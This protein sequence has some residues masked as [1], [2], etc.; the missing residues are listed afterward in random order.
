M[1]TVSLHTLGCKL[2]H[3]ETSAMARQFVERG[4]DVVE[5]GAGSDV[6]V[7]NTC[8]VTDRADRECRQLIR[9]SLRAS[10]NS[11]VL[12]TGCYAQLQPEEVASIEGVGAVLG[13]REKFH[14]FEYLNPDNRDVAQVHVS[15]ISQG[16]DFG[17]AYSSGESGRTRGF[18]KVQDGCDYNCSFCTIPLARGISRSQPL[19]ACVNQA[20]LLASQGYREIVLTGVNVGDYGRKDSGGL[21]EL[22]RELEAVPGIERIRISS[23]EP[24]LLTDAVIDRVAE[25]QVLCNHFH[26]PLQSGDDGILRSMRRRYTTSL[27]A[28]RVTRVREQIPDCGIGVDVIVGFPG[29]TDT[30]FAN[31]VAFLDNLPVSYLHVFTYS[32]RP[33]TPAAQYG[34][35]VR[36]EVRF[37]RSRALRL[38]GRKKK[39]SFHESVVGKTR[40]VLLEGDVKEGRRFGFTEEYVR[41]G[42][43]AEATN[44]NSIVDARII[45]AEEDLCLGLIDTPE[46]AA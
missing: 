43:P 33:D 31:T 29:E 10:G 44:E 38:L 24:N 18:L 39:R 2:N 45:T 17:I 5:F 25:S 8:S 16:D 3:A 37:E 13:S 34:G 27:Y 4:Y 20:K 14:I 30:R 28:D 7:I 6:T 23:I 35:Q 19:D 41:V 26:I 21:L 40:P 11:F 32:E 46:V 42:V 12:V 36:P 9:R 22:L 15:D 1:P